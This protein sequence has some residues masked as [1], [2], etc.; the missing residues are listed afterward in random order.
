M[1]T[2][3]IAV[4]TAKRA[5]PGLGKVVR[6]L[7]PILAVLLVVAYAGIS[8][9]VA[10]RVSR[11]VR[12]ALVSSPAQYGLKYQDVTFPSTVDKIPLS[13]W[14]VD[15]PGD[16]AII[17]MHGRDQ[18]RESDEAYLEK[19]SIFVRS[20]YDVLMFDFRAHGLSGG[21][22]YAF[23][24]WETR[25]VAGALDYLK[26]RGYT[27]FGTYAVSMGAAI[28]LLAAPD[29][30][31][32]KALWVDSP[33]SN[34][35]PLIEQRLPENSGLPAFF[36]PGILFMGKVLYGYD[37][38]S[39]K[40]A[41]AVAKMGDRAIYQ[42]HIQDGD[43]WVPLSQAREIEQAGASNPDFSSWIAPG[44]GHVNSYTSNKQEYTRRMLD[45]YGKY[46]K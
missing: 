33:F 2:P 18:N 26:G 15:S 23:G 12:K 11:P 37:L 19:A 22:R 46:L 4:R 43:D 20:N 45:F 8:A 14:L 41:E 3:D 31:E 13:G 34:L 7:G 17:M 27:E 30:P 6:I 5:R 28:S 44:S 42:V 1:G 25:D 39:L 38:S 21:E 32:I 24:Q 36:N 9:Y 35:V 40:P 29:R 16:K 10:D